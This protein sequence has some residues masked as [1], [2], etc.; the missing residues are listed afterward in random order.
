MLRSVRIERATE[1]PL[2]EQDYEVEISDHGDF[3]RIVVRGV[4]DLG[5]AQRFIQRVRDTAK[6][7]GQRRILIDGR[8]FT[9]PMPNDHRF[10]IGEMV[11]KEWPGLRVAV[12]SPVEAQN[13]FIETVAVNRGADTRGFMGEDEA[14]EWLL[15]T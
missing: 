12:I 7:K 10:A 6:A 14:A 15:R 11:A 13:G 5:R 1:T 4:H 8:A 2:D 3:V 9:N